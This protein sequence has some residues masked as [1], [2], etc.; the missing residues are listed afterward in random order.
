MAINVVDRLE[1]VEID[2]RQVEGLTDFNAS[3]GAFHFTEKAAPIGQA[4]EDIAIR[5]DL[6][7]G[8]QPVGGGAGTHR[9]EQGAPHHSAHAKRRRG[10]AH[11]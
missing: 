4:G 11:R 8:A 6:G 7:L 5:H 9:L 3:Q 10:P 2:E 1:T